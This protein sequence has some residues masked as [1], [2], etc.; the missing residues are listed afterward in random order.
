MN[1]DVLDLCKLCIVAFFLTALVRTCKTLYQ[2]NQING[3][4]R[5]Q[6]S[7]LDQLVAEMLILYVSMRQ[8][9]LQLLWKVNLWP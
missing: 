4:I 5:D 2:R 3:A 7:F 8:A 6:Q 9:V 1:E